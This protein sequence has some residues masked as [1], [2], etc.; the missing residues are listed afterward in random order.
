MLW[1][2]KR[3]IY[4]N[5]NYCLTILICKK[6]Q[7]ELIKTLSLEITTFFSSIMDRTSDIQVR[8]KHLHHL[9]GARM[10]MKG[11]TQGS[12]SMILAEIHTLIRNP[13]E[14]WLPKEN[15]N[16]SHSLGIQGGIHDLMSKT[17]HLKTRSQLA[18]ITSS[19]NK[20]S[21]IYLGMVLDN[22]KQP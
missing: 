22:L 7:G 12:P 3:S 18:W 4:N 20:K 10:R 5:W 15:L 1:W 17:N 8:G 19:S 14:L 2:T 11:M 6:D 21:I 16:I 9:S 13:K